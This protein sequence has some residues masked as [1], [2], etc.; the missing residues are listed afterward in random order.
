M[1]KVII[2]NCYVS[3]HILYSICPKLANTLASQ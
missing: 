1:V 2:S 3:D